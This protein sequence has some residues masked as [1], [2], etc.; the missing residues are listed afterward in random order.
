[1]PV[2][3]PGALGWGVPVPSQDKAQ[4]SASGR[5]ARSRPCR[6]SALGCLSG[7]AQ[8][9]TFG[10][11]PAPPPTH[12]HLPQPWGLRLSFILFPPIILKYC[13]FKRAFQSQSL[14]ISAQNLAQSGPF[15]ME[16]PLIQLLIHCTHT[17]SNARN[18]SKGFPIP[19]HAKK[20]NDQEFL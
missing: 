12:T 2:P 15:I 5:P 16:K 4:G 1:M 19:F 13:T 14:E 18:A 9:G 7:R 11:V 20:G 17:A 10:D 8:Q 6:G 3:T